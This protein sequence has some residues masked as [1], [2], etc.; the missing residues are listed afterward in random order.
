MTNLNEQISLS[1]KNYSEA[2]IELVKD[3]VMSYE[4]I[5]KDLET[6]SQI[7]KIS[8]DLKNT[9]EYPTIS[10]E[11]K[12]E[13]IDEVFKNEI[14][15][16]II[17]FIKILIDKKRFSEFEQVKAD[18][19]DK[20]DKINNIQTMEIVSAIPLNEEYRGKIVQKL[21]EKLQKNISPIWEIDESIIAGLIYKIDDDVIDTSIKSKLDKLSKNLM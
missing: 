14:N 21:S 12:H 20:L 17:N 6:I 8:S 7:L 9:L 11:T 5:S 15:P 4:D 2:L 18:Y 10:T 3:N 13:I 19:A 16:N 1:A